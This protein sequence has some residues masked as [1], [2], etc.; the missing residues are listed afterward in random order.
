LNYVREYIT[1]NPLRWEF[2]IENKIN[3]KENN[4]DYYKEITEG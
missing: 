3:F 1:N 2:D 4:K